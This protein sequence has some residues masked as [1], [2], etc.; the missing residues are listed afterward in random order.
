MARFDADAD[1]DLENTVRQC[2]ERWTPHFFFSDAR[3][4]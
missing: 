1:P 3:R 2:R 4:V